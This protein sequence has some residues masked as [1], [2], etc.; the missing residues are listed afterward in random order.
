MFSNND[1]YNLDDATKTLTNK[2]LLLEMYMK[3]ESLAQILIKHGITNESE[4][5][6]CENY[7]KTLP[8]IKVMIEEMERVESKINSYK[9]DPQQHLRDLMNAKLNGHIK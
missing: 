3:M 6:A 9:S 4:I 7:V 5:E 2:K 8:H 1:F